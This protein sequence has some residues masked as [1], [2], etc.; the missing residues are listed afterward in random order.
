[1]SDQ[2]APSREEVVAFYD[3]YLDACNRRAADELGAYV[4]ERVR[5]NGHDKTLAEYGTDLLAVGEA[6]PDYRWTVR[7]LVV[8]LPWLAVHLTDA[9][10]HLGP[11]LG[12]PPSGRRVT[13]DEFAMYRLENGRIAEVWVTADNWRL[14]RP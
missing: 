7:H 12:Q 1:M 11:W 4:D 10:T 2:A 5:V 3:R 13:T 14:L 6:F 8:E 9:G